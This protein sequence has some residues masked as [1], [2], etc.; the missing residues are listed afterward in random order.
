MQGKRPA[1][2]DAYS[3]AVHRI[4]EFFD[5]CPDTLNTTDLESFFASLISSHS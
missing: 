3:R 1:T 5:L 2:I 4:S